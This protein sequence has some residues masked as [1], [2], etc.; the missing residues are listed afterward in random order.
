[1]SNRNPAATAL[2]PRTEPKGEIVFQT[3]W[4]TVLSRELPASSPHYLIHTTDFVAVIALDE[5]GD[6]LLVR[7]FREGVGGMT[8][9]L[10]SGHVEAGDTPE[11]SARKELVEETGYVADRFELLTALSPSTS[12]STNRLWCFFAKDVR[13]QP[14][15]AIEPGMEPVLY[16]KGL[17]ALLQE[18]EFCSAPNYGALCVALLNGKLKI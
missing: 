11:E 12:R 16:K 8:L 6:L 3:P 13:P 5:H 7:Q 2:M 17:K 10:P 14:G 4:F 15:V 18:P 1:M 9:E